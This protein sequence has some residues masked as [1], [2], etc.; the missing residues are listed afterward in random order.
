[1]RSAG[2]LLFFITE[3]LLVALLYPLVPIL[4]L[5]SPRL[6]RRY[7]QMTATL[8]GTSLFFV[9]GV[10]ITV[11]GKEHLPPHD[12]ICFV[13]NHE[14]FADIPLILM[15]TGRAPGFIAKKE[16]K[17]LPVIGF[18]MTA[19]RCVFIDR[20]SLRQGKRAIE[21][22]ARHIREGHPMV[23]FPEGTRSRSYTMRPFRHGSFKLAYL[24][25]A[26][27][28]PITIVGS[29]HLLEERGYLRKHPVEVHIHPPIEL[30]ALTEEE[31]KELPEKVFHIIQGPLLDRETSLP[32]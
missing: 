25:N 29:F 27:I 3:L 13:A 26:T 2:F 11:K 5:F 7:V 8:W 9:A 12:R 16:L 24:S 21:Q 28:V 6:A 18:W 10:P 1:M 32:S 14:G 15:A 20:K 17:M 31:R 23:I 19:L 22:G 4:S 30:S